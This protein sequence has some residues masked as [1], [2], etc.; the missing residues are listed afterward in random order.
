MTEIMDKNAVPIGEK[1]FY[2]INQ[3]E[4]LSN[5]IERPKTNETEVIPLKNAISPAT[6]TKDL[7]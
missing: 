1:T 7:R 6:A 2:S 5:W 3:S 4:L